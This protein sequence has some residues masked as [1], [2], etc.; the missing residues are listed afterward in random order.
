MEKVILITGGSSGIGLETALRLQARGYRVYEISRKEAEHP[1]VIHIRG[2]VTSERSVR[3]AVESVIRAEGHIDVLINNA[4]FGISGAVEFTDTEEAKKQFDVNFFGLVRM[5]R[6]VLPYMREAGQGR[7]LNMSSVAAAIPIPFQ[8]F[9]SASKAAINAYTLALGNEV[10]PCGI[11]VC[12]VMPGDIQTGFTAAREKETAGDKAYGGRLSR[13]VARMEQDEI[14]GMAPEAVAR[15]VARLAE[16]RRVKPLYAVRT[17]YR[18]FVLLSKILPVRL[19]NWIV[20]QLYA[21]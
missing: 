8:T 12:A 11:S 1:G 2:D 19:L 3:E 18:F 7:I 10:R 15:F 17:D 6:A 5:C 4:G 13:S 16:R 20:Y 14:H 9:Y 21:R